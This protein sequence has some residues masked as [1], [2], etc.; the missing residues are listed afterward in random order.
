MQLGRQSHVRCYHQ[1][2]DALRAVELV[3]ADAEQVDPQLRR[4]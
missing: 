2:A 3:A 1:G 4:L